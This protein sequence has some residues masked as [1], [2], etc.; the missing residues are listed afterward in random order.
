MVVDS[1]PTYEWLDTVANV[2][3]RSTVLGF[4]LLLLWLG[5][6]MLAPGPMYAQANW[7]GLT[8]HEVDLINYCGLAFVKMCVLL[9]FLFP[10]IAVRLVLRSKASQA[11]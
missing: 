2:L 4:L 3:L 11:Q 5:L 9:F 7:F 10:Y 1:T 8:A 6:Y